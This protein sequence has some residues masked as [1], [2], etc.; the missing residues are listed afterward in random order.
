LH[1]ALDVQTEVARQIG[2]ALALEL[3]PS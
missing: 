1:D 3:L 2:K